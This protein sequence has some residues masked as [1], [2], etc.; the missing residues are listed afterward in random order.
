MNLSYYAF[1]H[2]FVD[3][4]LDQEPKPSC[5]QKGTNN[6]GSSEQRQRYTTQDNME[7]WEK[8]ILF[9]NIKY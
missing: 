2:L 4:Q 3:L 5:D 6:I 7:A 1:E 9:V 8:R